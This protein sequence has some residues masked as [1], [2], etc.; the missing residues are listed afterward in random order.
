MLTSLQVNNEDKCL[1]KET[2]IEFFSS[3]TEENQP[4]N[5]PKEHRI[6]LSNVP[7]GAKWQEIDDLFR[8]HVGNVSCV[9]FFNENGTFTGRGVI[10]FASEAAAKNAVEKMHHYEY[11]GR[12]LVVA[13][14]RIFKK[15]FL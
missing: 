3:K 9:E 5:G 2:F 1:R 14:V 15:L 10:E 11:N 6:F 12:K 7:F 13:K 4:R 8:E